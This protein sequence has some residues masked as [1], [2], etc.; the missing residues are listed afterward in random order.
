MD[1]SAD[2][3]VATYFRQSVSTMQLAADDEKLRR[4]IRSVSE[5]IERVFSALAI[6]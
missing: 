5:L 1:K 6:S 3:L 4:T 2:N